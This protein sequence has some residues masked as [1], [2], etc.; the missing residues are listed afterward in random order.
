MEIEVK[1]KVVYNNDN[2][3]VFLL[4]IMYFYIFNFC[5]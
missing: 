1:I 5:L 3:D 4:Y 2:Y